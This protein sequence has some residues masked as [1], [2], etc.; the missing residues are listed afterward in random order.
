MHQYSI[1]IPADK[2]NLQIGDI[3]Q[4]GERKVKVLNIKKPMIYE[5]NDIERIEIKVCKVK[6]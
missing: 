3:I 1:R 2:N 4:Y 6:E 5:I